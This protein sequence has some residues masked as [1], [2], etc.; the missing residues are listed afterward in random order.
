MP[1]HQGLPKDA[2]VDYQIGD[3]KSY[4]YQGKRIYEFIANDHEG[5]EHIHT[6]LWYQHEDVLLSIK[7]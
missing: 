4:S 6:S 2:K 7:D 3:H 5:R 1:V